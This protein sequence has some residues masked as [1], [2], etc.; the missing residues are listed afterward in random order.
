LKP[1]FFLTDVESRE[2]PVVRACYVQKLVHIRDSRDGL[3]IVLDTP[4]KLRTDNS[5]L[6][7]VVLVNRYS[8]DSLSPINCWPM[9]VY[10]CSLKGK[11]E[12]D[13]ENILV[14]EISILFWGQIFKEKNE[15][16][17]VAT[18]Y[19]NGLRVNK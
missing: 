7:K 13:F 9:N 2:T 11:G 10:V 1:D 18:A 17:N 4:I 19:A 8:G 14:E 6:D 12:V 3:F 5:S 15:A 16:N